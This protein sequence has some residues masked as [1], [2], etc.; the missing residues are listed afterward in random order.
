MIFLE[1]KLWQWLQ[2]NSCLTKLCWGNPW[3][4]GVCRITWHDTD[5]H[6]VVK[7]NGVIIVEEKLI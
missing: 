4:D 7:A 6:T 5:T 1:L 3:P 2:A